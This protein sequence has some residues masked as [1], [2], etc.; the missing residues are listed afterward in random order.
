[1]KMYDTIAAYAATKTPEDIRKEFETAMKQLEAERK[2]KAEA[3]AKASFVSCLT[4]RLLNH[5]E[6]AEDTAFILNAYLTDKLGPQAGGDPYLTAD[7]INSVLECLS[8][9]K[10]LTAPRSDDETISKFLDNLGL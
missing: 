2:A 1:M 5:T 6:T 8:A 7:G 4:N 9:F 10:N 3:D